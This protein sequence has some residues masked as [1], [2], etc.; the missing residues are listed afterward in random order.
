MYCLPIYLH[1]TLRNI[2]L[3]ICIGGDCSISYA[4]RHPIV[5][6]NMYYALMA[7]TVFALSNNGNYIYRLSLY[8]YRSTLRNLASCR[9]VKWL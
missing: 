3:F 1:E 9:K 4:G 8:L 6:M 5:N 7:L 2:K